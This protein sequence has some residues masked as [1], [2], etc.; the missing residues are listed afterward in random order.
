[1]PRFSFGSS[2]G[3]ADVAFYAFTA[4]QRAIIAW[5][6]AVEPAADVAVPVAVVAA[7]G[8]VAAVKA[9]DATEAGRRDR[10]VLRAP[11]QER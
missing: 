4:L 5:Q 8:A 7:A 11:K 9:G 1:M 10:D 2:R 3:V 6:V